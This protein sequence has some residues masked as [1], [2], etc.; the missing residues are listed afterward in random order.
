MKTLACQRQRGAKWTSDCCRGLE[1][2]NK[3]TS[4]IVEAPVCCRRAAFCPPLFRR[5]YMGPIQKIGLTLADAPTRDGL[6][7]PHEILA[8]ILG[9]LDPVESVAASRVQRIWKA[10]APPPAQFDAAYAAQLAARG[11]LSVLQWAR[12]SGCPWDELGCASAAE[13]GHLEVL[14]WLRANG[15]PWDWLTCAYAA[16]GGHIPVLQWAKTNGCTLDASTGSCAAEA[17]HL[18]VLQWLYANGC[19]QHVD[20][21]FRAAQGGH[22]H[23]LRWLRANG[24]PWDQRTVS[25]ILGDHIDVL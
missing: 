12:Q 11:H 10:L 24:C 13:A 14:Q 8:A 17:G 6:P 5:H 4:S 18:D 25:A 2:K 19:P 20:A 7:V 9:H 1:I 15:C 3:Q 21:C 23:I 22:L 16:R